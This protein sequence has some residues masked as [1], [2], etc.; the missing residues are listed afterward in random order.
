MPCPLCQ[1][2]GPP[3]RPTR[4]PS[5][6]SHRLCHPTPN[7]PT[8]HVDRSA[9]ATYPPSRSPLIWPHPTG[10]S[11]PWP[12]ASPDAR[13]VIPRGP[14]VPLSRLTRH[15]SHL[16][17]CTVTPCPPQ[18]SARC[19]SRP[20]VLL[21][22]RPASRLHRHPVPLVPSIPLVPPR[23]P[24]HPACLLHCPILTTPLAA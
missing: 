16:P 2:G 20:A 23:W 21:L 19:L 17:A 13:P 5:N 15:F 8:P 24:S 9:P 10:R 3:C 6:P 7:L 4:R 11:S 18:Q 14:L 1:P 12:A 22:F